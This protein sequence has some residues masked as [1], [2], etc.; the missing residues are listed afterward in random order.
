MDDVRI[1]QWQSIPG[2]VHGFGRRDNDTARELLSSGRLFLLKQ[3]HGT[4][5]AA[6]PWEAPPEADASATSA[7]GQILGIKTADCLPLLFVDP[8][9]RIAA[10][11]HAGWRG[12]AAGVA[13][14][15]LDWLGRQGVHPS[16][17]QVALGPCIGPCCYEVGD[18]LR[19]HFAAKDGPFFTPGAHGKPHLD[20]RGVNEAQLVAA[21][22]APANIVRVN[23]CTRCHPQ[24]YYSYRREGPAA[25]RMISYVGWTP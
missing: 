17:I 20:L 13:L 4:A 6:P 10:A 16:G 5:L 8:A 3:V 23:D 11:A 18:E 15:V 19:A 14:R 2:L 25:G 22:V 1:P 24:Q 21:G 7:G 12:T 9:R